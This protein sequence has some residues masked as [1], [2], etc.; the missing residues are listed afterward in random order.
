MEKGVVIVAL[1]ANARQED[2]DKCLACGMDDYLSKPFTMAQLQ[3]MI[4]KWHQ[5]KEGY[6]VDSSKS[7][8]AVADDIDSSALS[9]EDDL[10][11]V[12]ILNGIRALQRAQSPDILEQLLE[13][14]RS[15]APE[16]IK[17][18]NSSIRDGSFETIRDSAH[19]LKSASG[20]IGARKIFQL[21]AKLE[22]MGRDR[23]I[24]GA[25]KILEEIEKFYP[26]VCEL[27]EQEI[28]RP[29]A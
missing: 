4:L 5:V 27:L 29:A 8:P 16:L 21:S 20:N 11:D 9:A 1:T 6:V 28:R 17:N 19:S 10:L 24:D 18:L 22:D 2:R 7:L 12:N 14:Y 23:A 25:G 26:K 15:H 3:D 13:I